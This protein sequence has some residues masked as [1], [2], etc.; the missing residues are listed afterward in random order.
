MIDALPMTVMVGCVPCDVRQVGRL[1][2]DGLPRTCHVDLAAREVRIS[3]AV[4]CDRRGRTL[5]RA[6]RLA[7]PAHPRLT[8]F[9]PDPVA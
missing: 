5:S 1:V 6:V 7:A 4:P 2:I 3:S 8:P 9:L